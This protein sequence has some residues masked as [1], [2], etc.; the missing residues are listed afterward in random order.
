MVF[1]W[2]ADTF[3]LGR[4][5]QITGLTAFAAFLA[6]FVWRAQNNNKH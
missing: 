3:S 5:L 2:L 1:G 4:A 6:L